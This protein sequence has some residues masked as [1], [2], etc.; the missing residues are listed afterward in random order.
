MHCPNG[1]PMPFNSS[2]PTSYDCIYCEGTQA[3]DAVDLLSEPS[4]QFV[5][6]TRPGQIALAEAIDTS[7][8]TGTASVYEAGTGIGKSYAYLL[9][10]IISGK[11]VI[12]ST[13]K[14]ALQNQLIEKDLPHIKQ[15]LKRLSHPRATFKFFPAYGKSNFACHL[16]YRKEKM[17]NAQDWKVYLNFSSQT[18]YQR[19]D[20]WDVSKGYIDR[21]L[22]ATNCVGS[23]CTYYR[24]CGYT[25]AKK[26]VQDADVVVTNNWLLG[27]H[28]RLK[29]EQNYATLL[30]EYDHVV[31]DEAHKIE[32]GIRAAFS[33]ET[34]IDT[35]NKLDKQLRKIEKSTSD[36][37]DVPALQNMAPFWETLFRELAQIS[38][39]RDKKAAM[40]AAGTGQKISAVL[41]MLD[42][43]RDTVLD[44]TF[45]AR[46]FPAGNIAHAVGQV[47]DD[48]YG[49][50]PTPVSPTARPAQAPTPQ[51]PSMQEESQQRFLDL[52]KFCRI[53]QEAQQTFSH[54]IEENPYRIWTL[55]ER[56]DGRPISVLKSVPVLIGNKMPKKNITYLSA[57]LA[58][59]SSFDNFVSR[60]GLTN[61]PYHANVFPSPFE[62]QKQAHLFVPR[63]GEGEGMM[64]MPEYR[65]GEKRDLYLRALATQIEALLHASEG[66]AFVLF[67]AR[68]E[69]AYV[70]NHLRQ[71]CYPFPVFAQGAFTPNECLSRFRATPKSTILGLK[72]FWEGVDVQGSKLFLV[73]ISKM[74]FPFADDPIFQ[75]RCKIVDMQ[76]PGSSAQVVR[77]PDMLFDL[78]QG[79]GRL[80][81]SKSDRGVIAILDPR[82]A[83]QYRHQVRN[84]L[85]LREHNDL[86]RMCR[87]IR[88]RHIKKTEAAE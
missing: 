43:V 72:S 78:R 87:A 47:L 36:V 24:S 31:V 27:Y 59:G 7:I 65:P 62:I 41:G 40:D 74:P 34:K 23:A 66:D 8:R 76:R 67:T 63:P 73:I 77:V 14:I 18:Q 75:A 49:P 2:F 88:T 71:A 46:V 57:T 35:L 45:L 56:S 82:A 69:L 26:E 30:G 85:G 25:R 61:H 1:H 29:A 3:P 81:R 15:E 54:I 10:S 12:I 70:E 55:E 6:E 17:G 68:N 44:P 83:L 86:E 38:R 60:V 33:I 52:D 51:L 80:I 21:S 79:V 37:H 48:K 11:R 19:F 84:A 22:N 39:Q 9:P 13:A 32:E 28:L 4:L 58:L 20:E 64:P 50:K 53:V 42:T 16:A 5:H